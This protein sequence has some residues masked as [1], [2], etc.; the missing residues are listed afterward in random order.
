MN[1]EDKPVAPVPTWDSEPVSEWYL[2]QAPEWVEEWNK[3]LIAAEA[4]NFDVSPLLGTGKNVPYLGWFWRHVN[5]HA[6]YISL[7]DN[8]EW[9]GFCES[10]KWDYPEWNVRGGDRKR[11]LEHVVAVVREPSE[12]TAT[13]LY[14]FLQ[15]RPGDDNPDTRGQ[16]AQT[17]DE[18]AA[19][20]RR[21]LG[22][23]IG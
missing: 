5:F 15:T 4:A 23:E 22:R 6:D 12:Q 20:Q 9:V 16:A 2:F 14:D 17:R 10:N 8:G 19:M 11:L 21:A 7:A 1:Y 18:I 13:A 3:A